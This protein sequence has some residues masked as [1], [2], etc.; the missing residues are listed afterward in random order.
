MAAVLIAVMTVS[1]LTGSVSALPLGNRAES[2]EENAA[3][4][5]DAAED[6]ILQAAGTSAEDGASDKD[7][8][9]NKNGTSN[10]DRAS[11]KNGA[12][13]ED[14]SSDGDANGILY[15]AEQAADSGSTCGEAADA[16]A[17]SG[18]VSGEFYDGA[19]NDN[20]AN[21]REA[22]DKTAAA[23]K[24]HQEHLE[25]M[26]SS[27]Y[28][29]SSVDIAGID[30]SL[31][32][33][34]VRTENGTVIID[35]EDILSFY[36]DVYLLQYESIDDAKMA[37]AYY[38][39]KADF[40]DADIVVKVA[41]G[42]GSSE[43]LTGM[44]PMTEKENPIAE[45]EGV[46]ESKEAETIADA[47]EDIHGKEPVIA[48]I[49]TGVS[50]EKN[51]IGRVSMV[52]DDTGDNNG[53]GDSMFSC[54]LEENPDAKVISVKALNDDGKGSISSV[55]AAVRYAIDAKADMINLSLCAHSS[56]ENTALAEIVKEAVDAGII[57][58]GAA[59]NSGR[60]VRDYTPGNIEEALIAGA[61]DGS[62]IRLKSSNYG[63]TVD[64]N[65]AAGSTSE[66]AAR[67]TGYISANFT[68]EGVD[69]KANANGLIFTTD[70][71]PSDN[72]SKS[73]D[74]SENSSDGTVVTV[75]DS[76]SDPA[77][78]SST[79]S[80]LTSGLFVTKT[81]GSTS[82]TEGNRC[83]TLAGAEY[84]VYN[85][86]ADAEAGTNAITTLIT[87]E[88]G[89]TD[90]VELEAGTY[91]IH[92]IQTPAGFMSDDTVYTVAIT[93]GETSEVISSGVPAA[94]PIGLILKKT[95]EYSF[96]ET[97]DSL[98]GA[99]YTINYYD[100]RTSTDDTYLK[101]TWV[102]ETDADG[103]L[104]YL[105]DYEVSGGDLFSVVADETR[106]YVLP[107]GLVTIRE[108]KAPDGFVLNDTVY[109]V[110]ID[111]T[112][113]GGEARIAEITAKTS[114]GEET[115]FDVGSMV[116]VTDGEEDMNIL[117]PARM[118]VRLTTG[119]PGRRWNYIVGLAGL[120]AL[121]AFA[122]AFSFERQNV[123]ERTS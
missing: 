32:R 107:I 99:Q 65:V 17:D 123:Y 16:E 39:A 73:T 91:Y 41:A 9:S 83:Y 103:E 68:D 38:Y 112:V 55:Y 61:C 77:E 117:S 122:A 87:D 48:L 28:G 88:D 59:G 108:T 110:A 7:E 1:S 97:Y 104:R 106:N 5:A 20:A 56:K 3:L 67:L 25:E 24:E 45:L 57:V 36:N 119:G 4:S 100:S 115:T 94:D 34:I 105:P 2:G 63:D 50:S 18:N 40:T 121:L 95:D 19:A 37:Y 86:N 84:G 96:A 79:E 72:V 51:V 114:Y 62:G 23:E 90:T 74:D 26:R 49:D 109:T 12:S 64:V 71:V 22:N 6:R 54:I 111:Q 15:K 69:L 31:M 78:V 44:D 82:I 42:D 81:S 66:A 14:A 116:T 118:Q 80:E 75:A 35:P 76:A 33:L 89:S 47:V 27:D 30:F 70:Y 8:T 52:G 102:F 58:V 93:A 101:K 120:A 92:E 43:N 46:S 29:V 21:D 113:N 10:K 13:G 60:D 98:E 11:A 53:H 85:T